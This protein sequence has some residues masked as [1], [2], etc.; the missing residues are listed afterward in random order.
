MFKWIKKKAI[1]KQLNNIKKSSAVEA[2]L[3]DYIKDAMI[4]HTEAGR[5]AQKIMKAKILRQTTKNTLDKI[6]ELDEEFDDEE[7]EPE[8]D[9]QDKISNM[10]I[11]KLL[12]GGLTPPAQQ[13]EAEPIGFD[14]LGEPINKL[15]PKAAGIA[16]AINQLSPADIAALK[17]KFLG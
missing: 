8:E 11:G 5:L 1:E 16:E 2:A 6:G 7:A 13:Q 4:E 14:D 3:D 9:L 17:K 10:L 15:P 12:G